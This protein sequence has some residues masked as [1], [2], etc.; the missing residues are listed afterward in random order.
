MENM[1]NLETMV[2]ALV[3]SIRRA[4]DA[5]APAIATLSGQLGYPTTADAVRAR[6]VTALDRADNEILVA[7]DGDAVVGWIH[8]YGVHTL[9][10]DAHAEIAGLIVDDRQRS[11]GI[12]E[13]LVRAAEQW[14]AGAGYRDAR[15]RSNVIRE[16]A[17]GFYVRLGYREVKRQSVLVKNLP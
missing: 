16:R 15:V 4:A 1:E 7:L 2:P 13:A 10:S 5:D 17:H 6:L 3:T 14:A 8:V 12:G 9:E 11:R